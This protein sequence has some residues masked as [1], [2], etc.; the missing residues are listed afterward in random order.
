M[1]CFDVYSM[2]IWE[3]DKNLLILMQILHVYLWP[4]RVFN[5]LAD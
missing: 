3:Y 1:K 4:V 2:A 5:I